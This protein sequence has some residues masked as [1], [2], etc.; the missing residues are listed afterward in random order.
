MFHVKRV[1]T[2][3]AALRGGSAAPLK[4]LCA[5]VQFEKRF[6]PII[7]RKGGKWFQLLSRRS[8]ILAQ[9]REDKG[10]G[11]EY[12]IPS[13]ATEKERGIWNG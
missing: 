5:A 7:T 8:H 2:S 1:D 9:K 3:S 6:S 10:G 4:K 13:C 11:T 12:T